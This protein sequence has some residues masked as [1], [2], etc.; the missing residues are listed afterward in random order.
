MRHKP[1]RPASSAK[2]GKQPTG[3]RG[4]PPIG[5]TK[6]GFKVETKDHGWWTSL[7]TLLWMDQAR[8]CARLTHIPFDHCSPPSSRIAARRDYIPNPL[9]SL[10]PPIIRSPPHIPTPAEFPL[11]VRLH[12]IMYDRRTSQ[13]GFV[14]SPGRFLGQPQGL[15]TCHVP[16]RFPSTPASDRCNRCASGLTDN[17]PDRDNRTTI[18]QTS[19]V[20]TRSRR[21]GSFLPYPLQPDREV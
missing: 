7:C 9:N 14:I 4:D 21:T 17:A 18:S 5:T 2:S 16:P 3:I 10:P 11:L 12:Q 20:V 13:P 6:S 19:L 1:I 15:R 8:A